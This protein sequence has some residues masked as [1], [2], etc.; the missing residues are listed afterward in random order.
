MLL[1][2]CKNLLTASQWLHFNTVALPR[3]ICFVILAF[4]SLNQ[5]MS[6]VMKGTII[7]SIMPDTCTVLSVG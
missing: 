1:E 3:F 6:N 2:V 5:P 7:Y 4:M